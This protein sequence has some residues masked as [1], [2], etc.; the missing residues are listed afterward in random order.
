MLDVRDDIHFFAGAHVLYVRFMYSSYWIDRE[1]GAQDKDDKPNNLLQ[2]AATVVHICKCEH[3]LSVCMY[4][5]LLH[6][7]M[8]RLILVHF[9]YAQ[10]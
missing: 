6:T 2:W 3:V 8:G 7:V 5:H 1:G 9:Y 4:G 10:S